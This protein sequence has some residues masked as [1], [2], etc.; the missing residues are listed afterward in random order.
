M[1]LHTNEPV[2][3]PRPITE[4]GDE[5]VS[6]DL[7]VDLVADLGEGYGSYRIA[8]DE[9]L[10]EIVT[11]ANV[12]CGFHAGDPR[13]MD[14]TVKRCQKLGV[15]VGAHPGFPDLAGFGR[16]T[17][18]LSEHEVLTDVLY[19]TGA[20]AAFAQR[21]G[22]KLAHVAPHGRLGNMVQTRT[23]YARAVVAAVKSFDPALIVL[24]QEGELIRL[25]KEEGLQTAVIGIA[26]R[27]YEDDGS[28]VPRGRPNAIIHDPEHIAERTVRMV[29]EGLITS[30]SGAELSIEADSVLLHG[31]NAD[32]VI[33]AG[34]IR[35]RLES[36]GVRV[37][38]LPEVL[39]A[40]SGI[41]V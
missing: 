17:I 13:T 30:V 33:L 12:A 11:S 18:E 15:S 5:A 24:G 26:D 9:A 1:C 3:W 31:D 14:S 32:S 8:D 4:A 10:L 6:A 25:A 28:L 20:L 16:R 19:Q 35:Q 38:P 34:L 29:T 27:A 2:Y 41:G 23:D 40:K 37:A 7:L 21:Y 36:A 39:A 22:A